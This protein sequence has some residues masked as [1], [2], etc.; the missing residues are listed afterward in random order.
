MSLKA[1]QNRQNK[2]CFKIIGLLLWLN[3]STTEQLATAFHITTGQLTRH[4]TQWITDNEEHGNH[5]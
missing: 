5:L 3:N 1:A 2:R 4:L